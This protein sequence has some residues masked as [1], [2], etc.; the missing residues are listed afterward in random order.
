MLCVENDTSADVILERGDVV[1]FAGEIPEDFAAQN[2]ATGS[3]LT[4]TQRRRKGRVKKDSV[5]TA[6]EMPTESS[7]VE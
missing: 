1:A 4:W 3:S 5:A 2:R 6:R 7:I